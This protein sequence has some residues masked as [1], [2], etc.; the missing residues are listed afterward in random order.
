MVSAVKLSELRYLLRQPGM[1]VF[2]LAAIVLLLVA[3][4]GIAILGRWWII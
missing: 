4:A 1:V 3:V 2:L